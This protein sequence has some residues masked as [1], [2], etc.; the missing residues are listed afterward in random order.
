MSMTTKKPPTPILIQNA[1]NEL[2][3]RVAVLRKARGYTQA[4]L[5]QVAGVGISTIASIEGGFDGVALGNVLK[6]MLAM[7]LLDQTGSLFSLEGDPDLLRY[8]LNAL[9]KGPRHG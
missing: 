2:G 5:A 7:G 6:V 8:A 1:L 9:S 3:Q 4:D